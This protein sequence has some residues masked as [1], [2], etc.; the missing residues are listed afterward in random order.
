MGRTPRLVNPDD[1]PLQAF[2]HDLRALREKAGNPT[3]R[4]LAKTAG[5]S[6]ST[7]GEAAGGV[8]RPSLDVTLAFV[9]AC[10][11]DVEAW[12][13]RW[14]Q[15]DRQLTAEQLEQ[16]GQAAAETAETDETDSA[17]AADPGLRSLRDAPRPPQPAE[18]TPSLSP[19]STPSRRVRHALIA[20]AAITAISVLAFVGV[21][22]NSGDADASTKHGALNSRASSPSA[23]PSSHC[24]VSGPKG[25]FA[26]NTRGS[27]ARIRA[28]AS[29]ADNVVRT[30]QPFCQLQFDG[31]CLGDVV[32]D[33][34]GGTPDMRWF[35]VAG[36]GEVS[37]AV[38]HGNPPSG[39]KPSA[40][41]D[42]VPNPSS[43]ALS[44]ASSADSPGAFELHATGVHVWIVGFATVPDD[45]SGGPVP[46]SAKWQQIGMVGSTATGFTLAWSA[47]PS[48]TAQPSSGQPAVPTPADRVPIVA[49]ACYGGQGATDVMDPESVS[50]TDPGDTAPLTLTT[51]QRAAA[52]DAACS[53]PRP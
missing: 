44:V 24:V 31:Y 46:A 12:Q 37:S 22:W 30:I 43:I 25:L 20:V 19:A 5:F 13:E 47:R 53:Y 7:L 38:I 4:A 33:A 32:A 23:S 29:M 15:L 21:H 2:A 48:D 41:P 8:R 52:A 18:P 35:E 42:S 9:G 50:I 49:V 1:G 34:F 39:L 40:C 45:R 3:Y 10:G 51:A 16:S 28:G 6:A 11:G 26:G 36:G 27:G 17:L 14:Q